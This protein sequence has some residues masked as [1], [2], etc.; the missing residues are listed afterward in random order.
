MEDIQEELLPCSSFPSHNPKA[1]SIDVEL[2]MMAEERTQ[3]ILWTIQPNVGSEWR[4]RGLISYIQR[5]IKGHFGT[6]VFSFGS[7]PLKTYLPD[8][9]IDLTAICHQNA[10]EEL[11][12]A[13]CGVLESQPKDSLFQ[14]K[15][16]RYVRAQ[17]K[18]VK[19]TVNNIAADISFNQM[20]GLC[21]LCFLEQ[22]DQQIGKDHLFKKSI[23]L[24]KAWCYYESRIL[25]SHYGLISTYALETLVLFIINL[26]HASLRGPL[27]VLL[28]FLEYYS[29]FDWDNYCI[30]INGPVAICSLPEII[31]APQ[32][33]A[34][35]LLLSEEFVRSSRDVFSDPI[36]ADEA[37]VH[38]FPTKHLNIVDP[39]KDENNL[40]RSVSKGNFYRIK[41]ALS[42]GAQNLREILKLPGESM[43]AEL[44]KF[45]MTT[46]DRNGRGERPDVNAPVCAFGIGRSEESDLWGE[47]D[48]YYSS[49]L[50]GQAFHRSTHHSAPPS[51]VCNKTTW[52]ALAWSAQLNWNE[53][54][55]RATKVY[56]RLPLRHPSAS[57]L[58]AAT[59]GVG[60]TRK[61]QGTGTFIPDVTQNYSRYV[62]PRMRRG[63]IRESSRHVAMMKSPQN[64]GQVEAS[65]ETDTSENDSRFNLSPEEFPLLPGTESGSPEVH[66]SGQLVLASPPAK[67]PSHKLGSSGHSPSLS[68][69]PSP[70]A[71]QQANT[72]VSYA[73]YIMKKQQELSEVDEE[74]ILMQQFKLDD[75]EDFPP[76][77]L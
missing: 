46:I 15:D 52:N 51:G 8:G 9:D 23:I 5:L 72:H 26:F 18:V 19:F 53:F 40:G 48:S 3:E 7:V 64:S 77:N 13:V 17:V 47:Y 69:M 16:V 20:A 42:L 71:S 25:G 44:E 24:I 67:E 39:L 14:F 4:R 2:W 63:R 37:T 34:D 70:V 58:S 30:S 76:L 65:T 12:I 28:R 56:A 66:Q 21:T 32:I 45:F 50:Y 60:I 22:V 74:T 38:E 36:R 29:T 27:E 35:E 55:G 68:G 49:M 59:I 62:R 75:D 31:V 61:S 6:E 11:A 57:H 73:L 1:L 41:S 43:G 33:E 54:C 10:E